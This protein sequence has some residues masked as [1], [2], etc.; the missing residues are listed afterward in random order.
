LLELEKKYNKQYGEWN[1]IFCMTKGK[2]FKNYIWERCI[3]TVLGMKMPG[4][5]TIYLSQSSKFFLV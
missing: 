5:G 4:K 3:S 1:V 2:F